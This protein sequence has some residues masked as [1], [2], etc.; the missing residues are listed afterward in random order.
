MKPSNL[1]YVKGAQPVQGAQALNDKSERQLR[2]NST[3]PQKGRF[4]IL[5]YWE[6]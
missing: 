2:A 3:F 4:F 1:T 5:T 6:F